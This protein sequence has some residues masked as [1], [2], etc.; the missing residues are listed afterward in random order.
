MP[1]SGGL[2]FR[3]LDTH[4]V[5]GLADEPALVAPGVAMSFA[6]LLD[7]SASVAAGLRAV[8]LAPGDAVDLRVEDPR[9][10]VV[11]ILAAVRLGLVVESGAAAR[12]EGDPPRVVHAAVDEP[13]DV[14]LRAGR[15]DPQPAPAADA[16]GYAERMLARHPDV[17]GPLLEGRPATL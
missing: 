2:A 16:D 12:V 1:V 9:T 4:V 6:E 5:A 15:G 10:R 11:T 7:A 14:I 8:G 3:A 17:L 13:W